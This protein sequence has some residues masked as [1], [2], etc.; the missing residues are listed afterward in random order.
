MKPPMID[1]LRFSLPA[2]RK[3]TPGSPASRD[4][5]IGCLSFAASLLVRF[6]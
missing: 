3:K 6:L 2:G 4:Q 5:V 1:T